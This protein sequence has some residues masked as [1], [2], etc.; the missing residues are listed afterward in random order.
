MTDWRTR[1]TRARRAYMDN[2]EFEKKKRRG[3][4]GRL[5]A[6]DIQKAHEQQGTS[7]VTNRYC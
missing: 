3:K 7:T 6:Q 2:W 5:K 4:I 1:K